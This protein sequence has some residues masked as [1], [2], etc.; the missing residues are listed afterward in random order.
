[1]EQERMSM[2]LF[3]NAGEDQETRW[4]LFCFEKN[5]RADISKRKIFRISQEKPAWILQSEKI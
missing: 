3:E 1:M 4:G 2:S 5:E